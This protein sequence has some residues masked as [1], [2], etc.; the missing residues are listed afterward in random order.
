MDET[1]KRKFGVY[2]F[3]GLLIGAVFGIFLGGLTGA[4]LGGLV[5]AAL[6]WFM[7]GAVLEAEKKKK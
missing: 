4:G 6:G 2:I 3:L 7:A 5:G 1:M